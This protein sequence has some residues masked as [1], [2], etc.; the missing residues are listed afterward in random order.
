M[1]YTELFRIQCLHGYFGGGPCRSLV[2]AP[3]QDCQQML[4]RYQML[5]RAAVGGGVVYGPRQSPP[6]LLKQFDETA[7]FT[8]TLTS[9]DA[10]LNNYTDVDLSHID[11]RESIFH[12]DNRGD[13]SIQALGESRQLL[14]PPD[15]PFAQGAILVRPKLSSFEPS[16][17][18]TGGDLK[19]T[20]PLGSQP[21]WQAPVPEPGK[22]VQLDLHRFP[23]GLYSLQ[24][25]N[26]PPQQFLLTDELALRRWGVI[27]IYA[28]GSR[29]SSHLLEKCRVIDGDGII[30]P[31]IFTLALESRK[32][33]WRYYIIPAAEKQDLGHY[34]LVG[35]SKK[36]PGSSSSE[37]EIPFTLLPGTTP[38]DGRTA[39]V[40]ESK[41][42]LPFLLSPTNAFSLSLR[43][44]KNGKLGQRAIRL[45]YAQPTSVA[46]KEGTEPRRL[47]S[48]IFVYV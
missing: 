8:F 9:S 37:N 40:F 35:A 17:S 22:P 32:T 20:E 46:A 10:A 39:W 27:S 31:K 43:P 30:H 19:I 2:L 29:Q 4:G 44:N 36:T 21:I 16:P 24:T 14:H 48:E 47:C 15:N 7:P 6:D 18:T 13:H 38:V 25:K 26:G 3:T 34:E 5:F 42:P 41:S 28:G 45:P 11:I 12:F 1:Q 23:E 33:F